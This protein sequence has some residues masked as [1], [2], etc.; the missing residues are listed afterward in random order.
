MTG[1]DYSACPSYRWEWQ[2]QGCWRG[3]TEAGEMCRTSRWRVVP[4]GPIDG[5]Q[6]L[7]TISPVLGQ[8]HPTSHSCSA[9]VL[10][11]LMISSNAL[12]KRC[13]E[14]RRRV[15]TWLHLSPHWHPLFALILL[16]QP[17]TV[18]VVVMDLH[19]FLFP[20]IAYISSIFLFL[21]TTFFWWYVD[22]TRNQL[23]IETFRFCII[24]GGNL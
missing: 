7:R 9:M 11:W 4:L 22:Y 24:N 2:E 10:L 23:V 15:L 1:W 19:F 16:L 8:E 6:C 3:S 20:S 17:N 13:Y 12:E 18:R 14:G 5:C 21:M